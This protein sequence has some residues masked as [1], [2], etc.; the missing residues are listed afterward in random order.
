LPIAQNKRQK[1]RAGRKDFFKKIE[2]P[3]EIWQKAASILM[4]MPEKE[5]INY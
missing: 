5:S 1:I 3:T 2:I 4:T